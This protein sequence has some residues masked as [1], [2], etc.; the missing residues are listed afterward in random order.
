MTVEVAVLILLKAKFKDFDS[1]LERVA[2]PTARTDCGR[3]ATGRGWRGGS[4]AGGGRGVRGLWLLLEQG[5]GEA[6]QQE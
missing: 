1:A 5:R 2:E 6:R 4:R 3:V